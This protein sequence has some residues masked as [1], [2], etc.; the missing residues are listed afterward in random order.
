MFWSYLQLRNLEEICINVNVDG[1]PTSNSSLL[2]FWPILGCVDAC[3]FRP[4]IKALYAGYTKPSKSNEFLHDF[5]NEV[6]DLQ[7]NGIDLSGKRFRFRINCII[8][9]APARNFVKNIKPH[10]AY[11]GCEKCETRGVWVGRVVFPNLKETLRT[12]QA[13][14]GRT[15]K[16]HH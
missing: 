14:D 16:S 8:A 7:E 1:L 4:F 15:D 6:V 3:F 2:Q 11:H 12:D 5:V 13:F 10:N 9:D